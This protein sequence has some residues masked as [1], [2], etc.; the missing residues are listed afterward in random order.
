M[1]Q[2]TVEIRP[3]GRLSKNGLRRANWQESRQL[4]AQ[5]REDGFVLG[6]IEMDDSWETP[7]QASVSIVQY[8]ADTLISEGN[9]PP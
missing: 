6:R 7:D 8:Y 3:D 1:T 5:A 2:I 4:I 9:L